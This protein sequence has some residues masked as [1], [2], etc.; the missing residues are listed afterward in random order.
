MLVLGFEMSPKSNIPD[1]FNPNIT[2]YRDLLMNPGSIRYAGW[3]LVT[4]D[5]PKIHRADYYEV[6]NGDRKIIRLYQD[7]TL[8]AK[9]NLDSSFLSHAT[10]SNS[11][12]GQTLI[13]P[14]ALSEFIYNF[15]VFSIR[16][17]EETG[18]TKTNTQMRY[19]FKLNGLLEAENVYALSNRVQSF[20]GKDARTAEQEDIKGSFDYVYGDDIKETFADLVAYNLV[21]QIFLNFGFQEDEIPLF[22]NSTKKFHVD[23]IRKM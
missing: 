23:F 20:Y 22:D 16:I 13:N 3:D 4:L 2:K 5:I 7:G 9:G 8:I 14:I 10:D 15:V 21:R 17:A 11:G 1:F 6:T 12:P 19:R 18:N